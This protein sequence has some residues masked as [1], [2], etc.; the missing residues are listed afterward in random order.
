MS[1]SSSHGPARSARGRPSPGTCQA[2]PALVGHAR[3]LA[4]RQLDQ[5]GLEHLVDSTELIVSEL[6]TNA[7][8]HGNGVRD[9]RGMVGLRLIRHEMLT[10]EVSDTSDSHP[11]LRHPRTTDENGRGLHLVSKLSR[12]W[13]TRCTRDGKLIWSEQQL[14]PSA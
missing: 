4:T 5:W 6:V 11:R 13:G 9:G 1:P 8:R 10:C 3:T 7:I 12:R 14:A 2:D